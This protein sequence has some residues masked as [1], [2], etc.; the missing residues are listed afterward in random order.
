MTVVVG[1]VAAPAGATVVSDGGANHVGNGKHN[2]NSITNNSPTFNHGIQ[3]ISNSVAAGSA[4]AQ[5]AFC[6][7]KLRHCRISQRMTVFDP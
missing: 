2:K 6:K 5:A 1:G 7:R 3:H 4:N